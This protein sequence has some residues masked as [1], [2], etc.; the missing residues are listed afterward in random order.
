[1]ILVSFLKFWITFLLQIVW[2]FVAEFVFLTSKLR[3]LHV[4]L[5]VDRISATMSWICYFLHV[6]KHPILLAQCSSYMHWKDTHPWYNNAAKLYCSIQTFKETAIWTECS[7]IY[8]VLCLRLNWK[9][10][11][12]FTVE[13]LQSVEKLMTL[14]LNFH[15]E[16]MTVFFSLGTVSA[17]RKGKVTNSCSGKNNKMQ[18]VDGVQNVR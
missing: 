11:M 7:S 18:L 4:N 13:V 2:K 17:K 12:M 9:T 8:V 6:N 14:A 16:N 15:W 5:D 3:T 10:Q 1:M